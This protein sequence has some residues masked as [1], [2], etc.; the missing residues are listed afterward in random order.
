MS[1]VRMTGT[2]WATASDGGVQAEFEVM[3]GDDVQSVTVYIDPHT[4]EQLGP[5]PDER[6]ADIGTDLTR[7]AHAAIEHLLTSGRISP[8][9]RLTVLD[10][11]GVVEG[12]HPDHDTGTAD[13][14]GPEA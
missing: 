1:D 11:A 12:D 4:R 6:L 7:R 8:R 14:P 2:G 13:E 9:L 3:L 10:L 5:L